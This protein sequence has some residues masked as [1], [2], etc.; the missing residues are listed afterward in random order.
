MMPETEARL[1]ALYLPQI[2]SAERLSGLN[3][4]AWKVSKRIQH[5]ALE[6]TAQSAR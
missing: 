2:E 6:R 3:L 4:S 1:R 5:S